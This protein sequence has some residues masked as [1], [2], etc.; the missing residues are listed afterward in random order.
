MPGGPNPP[1]DFYDLPFPN[2][3]YTKPDPTSATGRR[4]DFN[5]LAM[6]RNVAGKPIDPTDQNRADGF[7]PGSEIV[8][9]IIWERLRDHIP[10]PARL[11]RILLRETAR[12][13]FEYRGEE[14]SVR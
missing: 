6:P 12:N 4:I 7:S 1:A 3:L 11:Y 9:K 14:A 13:F 8:T 10:A 5:L 2:D